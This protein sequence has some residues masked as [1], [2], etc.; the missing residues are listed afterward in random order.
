MAD[1][2][3][4]GLIQRE[5]IPQDPAGNLLETLDMCEACAGQDVD[6]FVLTEHWATGVLDSSIPDHM[7]LA[8]D[9]DGP[10]VEA[11]RDFCRESGVYLLA[12]TLPL[13][14]NSELRN[15]A[16]MIDPGGEII[17]E[18]S[19]IHLFQPLGERDVF[20]PG[21][22]LMACE[23]NGIGVG[24]LI[25]YDLRFP[26]PARR[27]AHAGCE[28]IAVPALWP[29]VRID[30]WETLLRA[31]AIENQV[32]MVGCNGLG[33]MAGRFFPGHSMI[34]SPNGAAV[35]SPEMRESAIVRTIDL[36]MLRRLRREICY[37]DDE[38]RISDVFWNLGVN[39]PG[40]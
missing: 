10:T 19:K 16:L 35:N 28:V 26:V 7:A 39:E 5:I 25:C 1:S 37:L 11:L 8:E 24:V 6:L 4:I 34:V 32:Y 36:D 2:L 14:R 29:E 17:L 13:K 18:Y 31:R 33:N 30:H 23:V 38:K 3:T 21:E 22:R 27:L 12:G 20:T 9:V 40:G 15:A